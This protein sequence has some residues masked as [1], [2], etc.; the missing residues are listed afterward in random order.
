MYSTSPFFEKGKENNKRCSLCNRIFTSI[1]PGKN[2]VPICPEC[3]MV[4]GKDD[5][6]SKKYK[7]KYFK[8]F[9]E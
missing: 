8:D 9:D 3:L 1:A 2:P 4:L 5:E 7:R 6:E